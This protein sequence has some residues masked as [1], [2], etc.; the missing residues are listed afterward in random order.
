[1]RALHWCRFAVWGEEAVLITYARDTTRVVRCVRAS[2]NKSRTRWHDDGLPPR[3]CR[4]SHQ[5]KPARVMEENIVCVKSTENLH[6]AGLLVFFFFFVFL[7]SSYDNSR[8]PLLPPRTQRG[9]RPYPGRPWSYDGFFFFVCFLQ[10]AVMFLRIYF[11]CYYTLP[12]I[13]VVSVAR[14]CVLDDMRPDNALTNCYPDC[15]RIY[16]YIFL[17]LFLYNILIILK[18]YWHIFMSD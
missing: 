6:H 17:K 12:L 8:N 2:A 9:S 15:F 11:S 18:L 14:D 10:L 1:M 5:N 7:L 3:C 16:S 4:S 13:V